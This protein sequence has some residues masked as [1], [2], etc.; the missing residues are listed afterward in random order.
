MA[1][2]SPLSPFYCAHCIHCRLPVQVCICSR[3]KSTKLPFK[4]I[5]CCHSKEWQRNDNTGQWAILSSE[6]IQRYRWHRKP[7]LIKPALDLAAFS[8]AD[9]PQA[10]HFLLFP[11]EDSQPISQLTQKI[12]HLW[13]IDGTWQEAQK[14][15]NQS[16]WLKSLPKIS[17][18]SATSQFVLRRN[19]QG[20]STMEAIEWAIRD[21]AS[22][23]THSGIINSAEILKFN[24]DLVQNQLLNL[25]R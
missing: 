25:L 17:I 6:D 11:A 1:M 21:S 23:N 8:L 13:I 12:T 14:M 19:Q 4:I 9:Y 10:G 2:L 22:N 16:P 15:L 18:T 20:L 5:L 24:F 3:I 7:E